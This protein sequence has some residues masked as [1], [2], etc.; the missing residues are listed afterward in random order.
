MASSPLKAPPPEA[1]EFS[2]RGWLFRWRSGCPIAGSAA[3]EALSAALQLGNVPLPEMTYADHFLE[4]AHPA[5]GFTLRFSALGA[6]R[7]WH[8][9]QRATAQPPGSAVDVTNCD[10]TFTSAYDG[11]VARAAGGASGGGGGGGGGGGDAPFPFQPLAGPPASALP[12]ELLT[13]RRRILAFAQVP[14]LAS[15]LNDRGVAEVEVKLRVTEDYAFWRCT[16]FTRLDG[17]LLRARDARFFVDFC[18][19]AARLARDVQL[20][21]GAVA[22]VVAA[23]AAAAA[24]E[25]GAA[26]EGPAL[27]A[28]LPSFFRRAA[29]EAAAP[30][31]LPPPPPPPSASAQAAALHPSVLA[32]A[33]GDGAAAPGS[34]RLLLRVEGGAARAAA[35]AAAAVW[36]ARPGSVRAPPP[37][38]PAARAPWEDPGVLPR[39][40]VTAEDVHAA[41]MPALH[42]AHELL[43]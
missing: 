28:G 30:P 15:D 19:P 6:L 2:H 5:S 12:L 35:A 25:E 37:P 23:A 13:E 42:E 10:W 18:A 3:L 41:L 31:P 33:G 24:G 20:R 17:G 11:E 38:P 21:V 4:V 1:S 43:L 7:S 34:P 27:P 26:G 8:A 40:A 39:L 22:G 14:L 16:A 36:P 32:A 9:L 29:A